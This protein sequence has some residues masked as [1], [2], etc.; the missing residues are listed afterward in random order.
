MPTFQFYL[1]GKKRDQFSGADTNRINNMLQTLSRESQM[2]NVETLSREI[3]MKNVEVTH[4]AL[5]TFYSEHAPEK[6]MEMDDAK[7]QA[8]LTKKMMEM[9]DAK[10]QAILTKEH[11]PG[12][13]MEMDDAKLQ[14]ILTKAGPTGGPGH[15]AL[16]NA[17]K[18]KYGKAPKTIARSVPAAPGD[19]KDAKGD[20]KVGF[21]VR[22]TGHAGVHEPAGGAVPPWTLR[23]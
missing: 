10:L 18:K 16:S 12:K 4:E 6:M 21:G 15:Y 7:L 23:C 1:F 2:K 3:Q 14:A 11:A 9:D 19:A 17:L 22:V 5:K 8:I 20:A 13:M